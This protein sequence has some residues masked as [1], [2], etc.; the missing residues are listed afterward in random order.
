MIAG[1]AEDAAGLVDRPSRRV[2]TLSILA[3]AL[4][5]AGQPDRAAQ[6][7]ARAVKQ[8][9]ALARLSV[10]PAADVSNLAAIS[11]I[12]TAA[13]LADR[14]APVIDHAEAVTATITDPLPKAVALTAL[15]DTTCAAG[16]SA[17]AAQLAD[18]AIGAAGILARATHRYPDL[19]WS[20]LVELVSG[21]RDAGFPGP[22]K[23]VV[24]MISHPR[25]RWPAMRLLQ[26]EPP[27]AKPAGATRAV[28]DM[29]EVHDWWTRASMCIAG[30][31]V[32]V[33]AAED[34]ALAAVERI[35]DPV[36]RVA[37]SVWLTQAWIDAGHPGRA[38]AMVARSLIGDT[39]ATSLECVGLLDPGALPV[40]ADHVLADS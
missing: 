37:A 27:G 6:V 24:A 12:L 17:R 15:A 38:N 35:S 4:V 3:K 16:Q 1:Q 20:L 14:A 11:Q 36:A 9:G 22:A 28:D 31:E 10:D 29:Q 8:A 5:A 19:Q 2:W 26:S 18:Q 40:I 7:A 23:R 13:G 25:G 30:D 39:W 32:S 21:L 34:C 33:R